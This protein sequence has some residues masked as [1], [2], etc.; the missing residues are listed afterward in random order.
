MTQD[1]GPP[2]DFCNSLLYNASIAD[3]A[4]DQRAVAF[5]VVYFKMYIHFGLRMKL[6][7]LR[8]V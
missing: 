4:V 1:N 5:S 3:S 7:I 2:R 6:D 8:D